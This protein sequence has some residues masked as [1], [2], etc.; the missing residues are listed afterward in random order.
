VVSYLFPPTAPGGDRG[1][2]L[3]LRFRVDLGIRKSSRLSRELVIY[4]SIS[5]SGSACAF[6]ERI[7]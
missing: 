5:V 3:L 7:F 4:E 2:D 6:D 1:V